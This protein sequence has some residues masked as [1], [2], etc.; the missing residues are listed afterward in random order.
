M[1]V[2]ELA[3]PALYRMALKQNDAEPREAAR[4][5]NVNHAGRGVAHRRA[6][7]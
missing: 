2:D 5:K 7:T 1:N 4:K 3:E 6:N